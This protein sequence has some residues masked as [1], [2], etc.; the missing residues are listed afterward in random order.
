MKKIKNC[1]RID[2][3]ILKLDKKDVKD[4]YKIIKNNSED[5]V[6]IIDEYRIDD[7]N[8]ID[9]I[10]II[11]TNNLE[12]KTHS[13]YMSLELTNVRGCLYIEDQDNTKLRGIKDRL[14][15]IIKKKKSIANIFM[16]PESWVFWS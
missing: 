6:F 11:K 3:P 7:I 12:I 15:E 5:F 10:D 14:L 4:I 9:N 8:E 16:L 1:Q 2:L 13:P